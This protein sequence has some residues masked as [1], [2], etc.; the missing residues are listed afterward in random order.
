MPQHL[1]ETLNRAAQTTQILL[2]LQATFRHQ[3]PMDFLR[4]TEGACHRLSEAFQDLVARPAQEALSRSEVIHREVAHLHLPEVLQTMPYQGLKAEEI[5]KVR[6]TQELLHPLAAPRR[7]QNQRLR[8]VQSLGAHPTME[9]LQRCQ[10][11]AIALL[12]QAVLR[13]SLQEAVLHQ[14][15]KA[16]DHNQQEQ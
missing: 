11:L 12:H 13:I 1:K 5:K 2:Q 10:I 15:V 8:A 7:A 9:A 16:R 6:P 14:E 4:Q 3:F